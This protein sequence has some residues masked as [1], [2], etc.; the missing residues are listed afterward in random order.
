M[1]GCEPQISGVIGSTDC[2]TTTAQTIKSLFLSFY[3]E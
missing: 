2:A 3:E 1:T